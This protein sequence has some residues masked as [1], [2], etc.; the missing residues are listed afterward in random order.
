MPLVVFGE[1]IGHIL[2]LLGAISLGMGDTK[3]LKFE[4]FFWLDYSQFTHTFIYLFD[5]TIPV[6]ASQENTKALFMHSHGVSRA[7]TH[8]QS[9]VPLIGL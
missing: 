5:I 6:V 7:M 4:G 1:N 9:A 8:T 2:A 3:S